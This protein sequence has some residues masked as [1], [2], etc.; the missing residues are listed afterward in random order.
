MSKF[1][2]KGRTNY[3]IRLGAAESASAHGGQG[4]VDAF[5]R[6]FGLW[7]KLSQAKGLDP[8]KRPGAGFAPEAISAQLIFTLSSGGAGLADAERVGK[9]RVLMGLVGLE[10]GAD[11]GSTTTGIGRCRCRRCG[12]APL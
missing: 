8:R 6:R 7:K 11:R 3:H 4:L 2:G 10:K 1:Y 12:A 9:D 5:C